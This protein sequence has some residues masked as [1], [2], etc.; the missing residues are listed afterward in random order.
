M[1]EVSLGSAL[2]DVS[3]TLHAGEI[4]GVAGVEG[5][6][7]RELVAVLGR[8]RDPDAGAVTGAPATTIHEDR[9]VE[10]LVLDASV[11]DN[12]VLGEL[13]SF[14]GRLGTLDLAALE[15]EANVRLT[16]SGAPKDLDRPARTLS[17]GN[18]QK[19]VV[20]RALA[21]LG[22]AR[23]RV[24]IAAQPTRGVDL[25]ARRDIHERLR[26]AASLGAG[27]LVVSADLD[28]LRALCSRILVLSRGTIVAELPPT[29]SDEEMGRRMLGVANAAVTA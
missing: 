4:V 8:D 21:R 11:R 9:Q 26:E 22:K 28:E 5:N 10:G 29:A 13:A 3:F 19:V 14:S 17:G 2:T 24:L 27:V 23:A 12:L 1:R 25:G 20:A 7:Q 15:T 16:R 18:Q 6:G